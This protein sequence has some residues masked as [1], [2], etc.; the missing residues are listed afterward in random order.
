VLANLHFAAT[1]LTA[2]LQRLSDALVPGG[3]LF[4]V[5]HDLVN[6]GRH[7]PSDPELL[8]T[9]ERLTA[10]MPSDVDVERI[11]RVDRPRDHAGADDETDVAVVAWARRRG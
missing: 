6:L 9:V 10:A 4:V 8:L 7:G 1:E 3:H 5:G 11:E 2:L